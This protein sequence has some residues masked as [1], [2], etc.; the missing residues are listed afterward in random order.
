MSDTELDYIP[1]RYRKRKVTRYI[2]LPADPPIE[3]GEDALFVPTRLYIDRELALKY[4]KVVSVV[5]VNETLDEAT[6]KEK[7]KKNAIPMTTK[8]SNLL[9]FES[10]EDVEEVYVPP[11]FKDFEVDAE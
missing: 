5:S 2:D 6:V 3:A 10:Y 7:G 4:A 9:R 11:K 8:Y 1:A